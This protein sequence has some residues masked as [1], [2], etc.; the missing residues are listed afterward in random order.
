MKTDISLTAAT[1]KIIIDTKYYKK[2]LTVHYDKQKL[3]SGHLYQLF[4][5]LK[6]QTDKTNTVE[7]ILLYPVVNQE[8]DLVYKFPGHKVSIKTINLAQSWQD[9]KA[10]L[11]R[12]IA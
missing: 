5:Y 11:L 9:I 12:I 8:L 10:E 7:G 1:R 2:A 6:N 4:A 3:I